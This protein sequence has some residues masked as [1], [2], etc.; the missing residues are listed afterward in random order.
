[1]GRGCWPIGSS[2]LGGQSQGGETV[3]MYLDQGRSYFLFVFE[4]C[5]FVKS[6]FFVLPRSVGCLLFMD[7][8]KDC[9]SIRFR[10]RTVVI[11]RVMIRMV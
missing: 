7:R 6:Q 3:T 1:M 10:S 8:L 2:H 4:P 9:N 5:F 11:G